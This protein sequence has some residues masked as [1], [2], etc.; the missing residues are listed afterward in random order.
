MT[1]TELIDWARREWICDPADLNS[2]P[3]RFP[4]DEVISALLDLLPAIAEWAD[5]Y[6]VSEPDEEPDWDFGTCGPSIR[7]CQLHLDALAAIYVAKGDK[8]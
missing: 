1:D 8:P 7:L 3:F 2:D 6:R 4:P 5:T